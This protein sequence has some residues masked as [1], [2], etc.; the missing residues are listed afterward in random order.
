M[1]KQTFGKDERIRKKKEYLRIYRQGS[2][3]Y[4][5]HFTWIILRNPA[6]TRRLGITAGKKA[7]KAVMRNRIKRLLR[8]F[9]RLHKSKL[10][11]GCDIV[12]TARPRM[13]VMTYADV[14]RELEGLVVIK[15]ND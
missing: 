13:P 6:G 15:S 11:E 8:E 2:R 10:P 7:G 1:E 9:F 12:V 5:E 4:S 3:G 14:S